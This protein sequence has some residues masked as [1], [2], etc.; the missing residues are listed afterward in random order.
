MKPSEAFVC[1]VQYST[2]FRLYDS[3]YLYKQVVSHTIHAMLVG[4]GKER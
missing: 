4:V 3:I 1:T 2:I